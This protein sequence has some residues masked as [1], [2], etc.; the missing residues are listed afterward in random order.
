MVRFEEYLTLGHA[1]LLLVGLFLAFVIGNDFMLLVGIIERVL[2]RVYRVRQSFWKLLCVHVLLPVMNKLIQKKILK[3][4]HWT[5]K[6]NMYVADMHGL[7]TELESHIV[8]AAPWRRR[9]LNTLPKN[10]LN[11]LNSRRGSSCFVF[12]F[13]I[14]QG[15]G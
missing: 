7:P 3:P 4:R 15:T 13:F 14:R 5:G 9:R 1:G 6:F 11:V 12:L 10:H 8:M 2:G